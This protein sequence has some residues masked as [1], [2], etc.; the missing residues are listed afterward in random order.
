[1]PYATGSASATLNAQP[2]TLLRGVYYESSQ[3]ERLQS[4]EPTSRPFSCTSGEASTTT[5]LDLEIATRAVFDVMLSGSAFSI[6]DV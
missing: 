2:H 6:A 3:P 5:G 4:R 1:M